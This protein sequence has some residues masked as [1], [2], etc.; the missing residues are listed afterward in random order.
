MHFKKVWLLFT[1][2]M[3]TIASLLFGSAVLITFL[4]V[5]FRNLPISLD[6]PWADEATRYLIIASVFLVSGISIRKGIHIALDMV[7]DKIKGRAKVVMLTLNLILVTGFLLILIYGGIRMVINNSDLNSVALP[8]SMALPYFFV[9]LGAFIM[10][11]ENI[12]K[13]V[14]FII[15]KGCEKD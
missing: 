1:D 13:E 8:I 10:L 2:I 14:P 6:I 5:I 7:I 4:S 9:P 15:S 11:I 12:M 3:E